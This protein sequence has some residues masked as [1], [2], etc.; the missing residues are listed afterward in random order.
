[1]ALIQSDATFFDHA[2]DN[3]GFGRARADGANAAKVGQASSLS[4]E[5]VSASIH[6]S[7]RVGIGLGRLEACPT[8]TGLGDFVNLRTHFRGGEKGV[9]AAVH[10]R[11]AGMRGLSV[12]R[13]SLI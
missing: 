7:R 8:F 10:R 6:I 1:M 12:K 3:A 13:L 2:G 4:S 11:A 9:F 5:R